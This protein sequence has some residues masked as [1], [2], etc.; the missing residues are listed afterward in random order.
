MYLT[1][2]RYQSHILVSNISFERIEQAHPDHGEEP[3]QKLR[4]E[5]NVL[6]PLF[7]NN[8]IPIYQAVSPRDLED[9]GISKLCATFEL[10]KSEFRCLH[11]SFRHHRQILQHR[12]SHHLLYHHNLQP[13]FDV[14]RLHLTSNIFGF[15]SAAFLQACLPQ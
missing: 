15:S 5:Q 1:R 12:T 6:F 7:I 14:L 3:V 11:C 8:T 10:I 4:D 13:V 2:G 9:S